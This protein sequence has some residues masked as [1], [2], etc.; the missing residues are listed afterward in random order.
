MGIVK[1][2]FGNI[3]QV[4]EIVIALTKQWLKL[5]MILQLLSTVM[6]IQF[7]FLF[8][9]KKLLVWSLMTNYF[10][11][12]KLSSTFYLIC[13]LLKS[14]LSDRYRRVCKGD[15][16]GKT[17]AKVKHFFSGKL[18]VKHFITGKTKSKI[19]FLRFNILTNTFFG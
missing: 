15:F 3:S 2:W 10:W 16:E 4:F 6:K 1:I 17:T 8:I 7:M 14:F 13:Q 19:F 9:F 18:W 5:R 11:N 12:L